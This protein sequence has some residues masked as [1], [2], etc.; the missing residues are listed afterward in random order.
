MNPSELNYQVVGTFE[1]NDKRNNMEAGKKYRQF[2]A[3]IIG[4]NEVLKN[5]GVNESNV[6]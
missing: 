5:V 6:Y 2:L 1:H 4:M 3:G